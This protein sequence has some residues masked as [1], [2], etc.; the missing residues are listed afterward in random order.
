MVLSIISS[1]V[2]LK[3]MS[4]RKVCS[5]MIPQEYISVTLLKYLINYLAMQV[6]MCQMATTFIIYD[7]VINNVTLFT[8]ITSAKRVTNLCNFKKSLEKSAI[9]NYPIYLLLQCIN[10]GNINVWNKHGVVI[11]YYRVIIRAVLDHV[12]SYN[13]FKASL[14]FATKLDGG[15]LFLGETFKVFLDGFYKINILW[16]L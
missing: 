9:H 10:T 3:Y 16:F 4:I 11:S 2:F 1:I 14:G 12:V 7:I 13:E 6:G 15:H 8:N 5:I